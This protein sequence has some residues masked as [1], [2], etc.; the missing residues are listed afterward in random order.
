VPRAALVVTFTATLAFTTMY[1]IFQQFGTEVLGLTRA[2]ISYSFT[3]VGLVSVLVQGRLVR[4]LAPKLGELRLVMWGGGLMAAGLALLP[5]L[6][7]LP[8]DGAA[9]IAGIGFS[10]VLLSAGFS[11]I[12][13][14][15]AGFV[16]R[17]TPPDD[18]GRVLGTLQSIGA[19]ARIVGPPVLGALADTEGFVV[20]F[21]L[22]ALAGA[23]AGGVAARW[24]RLGH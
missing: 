11:L 3:L 22:S 15:V 1:V 8:P 16:S 12:G 17:T 4:R 7:V 2:G 20:A 13:P 9:L 18:Q 10:V 14:C 24:K 5:L 21:G 19:A 23:A 6:A